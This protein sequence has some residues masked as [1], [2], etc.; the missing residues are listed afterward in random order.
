LGYWFKPRRYGYGATPS[1]WQGWATIAAFI[2]VCVLGAL[3]LFAW[4][5]LPWNII[6]FL[7]FMVLAVLV[8]ISIVRGKTD[9]AWDWRWGGE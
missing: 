4:A 9:G 8:L 6:A 1:T 3:A 2:V 5:P 7:A